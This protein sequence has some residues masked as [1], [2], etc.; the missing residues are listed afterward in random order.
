MHCTQLLVTAHTTYKGTAVHFNA[1]IAILT[2][3]IELLYIL[4]D[5]A[6]A[7]PYVYVPLG[8]H[9]ARE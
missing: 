9:S 3:Y 2:S 1:A 8:Q 7:M 4:P 5:A 6:I